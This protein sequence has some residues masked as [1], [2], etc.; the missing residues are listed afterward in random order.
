[1]DSNGNVVPSYTGTV[2]FTSS[3][4]FPAVLPA[5]YTFTATDQG[6]HTFSGG[7]TLFTAGSQ[8]VTVQDTAT[9]SITG[10]ATVAVSAGPTA[11]SAVSAPL[12][13]IAGSPF[14]VTITALDSDGN[15]MT[16]YTGTVAFTS[17]DPSPAVLP[18]NYTFTATDQ[19]V[20]TF[21]GGVTLFMAQSQTVTV[22]DTTTSSITGS[23]YRR[24]DRSAYAPIRRQC[25][26]QR[27]RGHAVRCHDHG[28]G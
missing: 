15:I 6:V 22:Q 19:G 12:S 28:S 8:T 25:T 11:E 27:G 21:S 9:S 18:A 3:D 2:A 20:H 16:G 23:A 5:N 17:T 4:P 10:S 14:D 24:G 13:A 7:V 26:P 1:M